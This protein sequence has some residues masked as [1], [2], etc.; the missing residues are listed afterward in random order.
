MESKKTGKLNIIISVVLVVIALALAA[1]TF[2][3]FRQYQ[4]IKKNPN[5]VA[6]AEIDAVVANVSKII[7]LPKD[8]TPT[9]ATV[10]DKDKLKDQPFFA[11]AQNGDKI[12]IYTKSK[13]AIIYRPKDNILVN[14][15][16]IVID[17]KTLPQL[18]IVD[19]GGDVNGAVKKLSDK[20]TDNVAIASSSSAKNKNS[21]K[22][23]V[24]LDVTGKSGD[25]ASQIAQEL[26]GTVSNVYPTGEAVPEGANIVI[27]VK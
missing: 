17:P 21:V 1:L 9:L 23:T 25:L 22:Q 7:D 5:Q 18:A 2:Y 20:F 24:V 4:N 19:A 6:Q 26:G 16:P 8:E 13:K 15:G 12:L 11:Q 27:F 3:F 14:V 10:Q